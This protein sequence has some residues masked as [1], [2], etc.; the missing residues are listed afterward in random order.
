MFSR[1]TNIRFDFFV[2]LRVS[3][4]GNVD[5]VR[6]VARHCWWQSAH[7]H[8]QRL[9]LQFQIVLSSTKQINRIDIGKSS[10]VC[11]WSQLLRA[12]DHRRKRRTLIRNLGKFC[13]CERHK[14]YKNNHHCYFY[15]LLRAFETIYRIA[16][17]S[18]RIL[19]NLLRIRCTFVWSLI[20]YFTRV[21]YSFNILY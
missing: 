17:T 16:V 11:K 1:T 18:F 13:S 12:F 19:M 20:F 14:Q 9:I 7:I 15:R 2:F 6:R 5:G 21:L 10:V 3:S 8:F 4:H